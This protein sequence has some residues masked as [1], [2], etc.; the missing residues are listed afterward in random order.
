MNSRELA[1]LESPNKISLSCW[2]CEK[3]FYIDFPYRFGDGEVYTFDTVC[4]FGHILLGKLQGMRKLHQ[5]AV[6]KLSIIGE[7]FPGV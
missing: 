4:P 3:R 5:I 6:G 7:V 2:K 1:Q